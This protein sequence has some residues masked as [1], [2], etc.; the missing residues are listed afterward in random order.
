M[1]KELLI[2]LIAYVLVSTAIS[3]AIHPFRTL[4]L[5]AIGIVGLTA[6]WYLRGRLERRK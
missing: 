3:L 6:G 2:L 5:A 4:E 1:I